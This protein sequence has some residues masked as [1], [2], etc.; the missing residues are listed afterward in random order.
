MSV[1]ATMTVEVYGKLRKGKNSQSKTG[2]LN[3]K[4]YRTYRTKKHL[5]YSHLNQVL[6]SVASE[7]VNGYCWGESG[8]VEFVLF[9]AA[10]LPLV[11][12]KWISLAPHK[13]LQR[14]WS[15]TIN[16]LLLLYKTYYDDSIPHFGAIRQLH[17]D[18]YSWKHNDTDFGPVF[19]GFWIIWQQTKVTTNCI[20][21]KTS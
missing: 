12:V 20:G 3:R 5:G 15:D 7:E 18:K 8:K 9:C 17:S 4:Y 21:K 2:M 10:A 14:H 13:V 19:D 16:S 1:E 6:Y 11:M